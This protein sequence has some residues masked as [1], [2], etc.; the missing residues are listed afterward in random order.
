MKQ[1]ALVQLRNHIKTSTSSM[2]SVPKPL[3]FLRPHYA[4]LKATYAAWPDSSENKWELADILSVLAMTQ[5]QARAA[6]PA[7]AAADADASKM[8]DVADAAAVPAASAKEAVNERESLKYK[9]LSRTAYLKSAA[10]KKAQA[11]A[12]VAESASSSSAATEVVGSVGNWGHEYVRNLAGEIGK[13]YAHRE[14]TNASCDDLEE[15]VDEILPF[16]INHNA[17]F[18]A[19]DLLLEVE[20]LGKLN[21][22]VNKD[23]VLR[24]NMYMLRCS[25][26]TATSEEKTALLEL[27]FENFL[28]TEQ[29]SDALRVAMKLFSASGST[30]RIQQ[31]FDNPIVAADAMLSKQL[32]FMLGSLKIVPEGLKENEAVMEAVGNVN[33]SA[34]FQQLASDLDVKE[35]KTPE[36]IYKTHLEGWSTNASLARCCFLLLSC[37]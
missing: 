25:D 26:Y 33:L 28:K 24:I 29:W 8:S 22:Y 20:K 12:P 35:A 27:V 30:E 15:L 21:K 6:E 36:D 5:P 14:E 1:Q 31:V 37:Y 10:Y 4:T 9:L 16:F 3:K 19:A 32:G 23:N 34:Y 11:A 18:D 13:E 7:A 17:D 2:T